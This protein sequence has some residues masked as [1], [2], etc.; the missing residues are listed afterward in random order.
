MRKKIFLISL[1]IIAT[2]LAALKFSAQQPDPQ[3]CIEITSSFTE[4]FGTTDFKDVDNSSVANWPPGPVKLN[5]LGANFE[6]TTP[7]GMGAKLYVCDAGDFDGDGY[8]DLVGLD[9]SSEADFSLKLIRNLFSDVDGDGQDDDGIIYQVDNDDNN[10]I[11]DSGLTCGPA[12]ITV[13]DYNGDGLLDFFFYKNGDDSFSYSNFVAVMYINQGTTTNPV[14][15]SRTDSRNLDFTDIFKDKEIYCN[16]A[17]NH[18]YTVDIDKDGDLDILVA[19]QDKIF[20]M[21]NPGPS[22]FS[23]DEWSVQELNY[24]KRTGYIA[25]TPGGYPDRGT[26]A[27]AAADFDLD[28]DID[29][30]CGSVNG[31]RYLVYYQNDGTGKFSRSEIAIPDDSCSTCTGTVAIAVA[32]FDQNGWK[33]IFVATD[34]WNAGNQ[35]KIWWLRNMGREPVTVTNPETGEEETYYEITWLFRCENNCDPIIPPSYDVDISCVTDYD[36]DG[37]YDLVLADANHSGDYYLITNLLAEVYV[38]YGEAISTNVLA[39]LINPREYAITKARIINLNQGVSGSYDGL[40]ITYY[41]S[42]D[43][44]L[45]WELYRTFEGSNIRPWSDSDWHIFS[46]F[47]GDLRWKA[48]LEATEDQMAEYTGASYDTPLIRQLTI[49]FTYV[50]RREYSRSSVATSVID[51]SGQNRKLIIAASFIYPGWEGHLRAYDVTGM[52]AV[53]NNYSN[54]RTVTSSDL[55]SETGR[56]LAEGV[57]LLWDAGELL[58]DRDPRTRTIYTAINPN[59][60][61][62]GNLQRVEFNLVNTNILKPILG[63]YQNNEEA[64]I[65]FVRGHGRYWRLGDINHSTPAVVGPP[66]EDPQMMGDG[67]AEFKQALANRRKVVYVGANDGML[68]CFDASS[69]EELW[70]FIPYNQLSRLKEMWPVDQARNLRYFSRKT[71]VDSSPS[72][73]DVY[74]NGQWRTVL[75]CGQ[76]EGEGQAPDGYNNG[77][78]QN[79]HYYYFALD[80]TDPENPIPMWEFAGA[81]IRRQGQNYNMTNGQTWS[82]PFIAR[83]NNA[84]NPTWVA[85]VGSGYCHPVDSAYQAYIG[86]S[87]VAIK[88]EDGSLLWS[89]RI[90]DLDSSNSKLSANPF[91]NIYVSLPGSPN[92]VDLNKDGYVDYIYIGDLDGRI[93]RLDLTSQ[94]PSSWSMTE[95]FR[96]RCLYPIITKPAIWLGFSTTGSNYPRIYFGTG[97]HEMAPANRYYSF[98]ALIDNGKNAEV[99]WYMGNINEAGLGASKFV[100]SLEAGEKVWADPVIA[101]YI[102]Y[103]STLKGSIEAADPCQNL[104]DFGRLYARFIQPVLGVPVGGSALKNAQGQA[105]DYLALAS[106]ARTAVTVGERQRAG[107]TYKQ[108]VYIQEYD[109]TIEKLEQPVGALLRIRSWREIYQIIR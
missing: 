67:Y 17:A 13:G 8:P 16:W 68:H 51:R 81:R 88:I 89:K 70:A 95:I 79:H 47:G 18:L 72:V 2:V 31:W 93:W 62:A 91:P 1:M 14:F 15:Y 41:L 43:G 75:V 34:R 61:A 76:G 105:I 83:V 28:G 73:S 37:D 54:L 107:S 4:N 32:D 12:A 57:E 25:P 39:N 108:D 101:N 84:G 21:K 11:F 104:G 40:K 56:W 26:S 36:Q 50:G 92:G 35:A 59:R 6:I 10:K 64:L 103:F 20:L 77:Q 78:T 63:D 42:N 48:V 60:P 97:G 71:Y 82:V 7:T 33:D 74:I 29:V 65:L 94:N 23:L 38:L 69:G 98:V 80:V 99:E 19:S 90:S 86:N 96:D 24:D 44:G 58:M 46:N 9:I 102:V 52:R 27:V 87:L 45:H 85:F 30:V 66:Q 100:G 106:K 5:R 53:Q 109:S 49:E 3:A 22:R 55:G